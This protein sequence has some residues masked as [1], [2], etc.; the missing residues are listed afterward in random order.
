MVFLTEALP[1]T[2]DVARPLAC[3]LIAETFSAVGKL[4]SDMSRT[5]AEIADL[6]DSLVDTLCA[7]PESLERG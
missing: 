6:A 5:E 4:F 1:T 2:P 7:Y 3:G